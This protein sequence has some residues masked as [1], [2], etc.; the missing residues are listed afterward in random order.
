VLRAAEVTVTE[1][2]REILEKWVRN[3]ASTSHRLEERAQIVLMSAEGRNCKEQGR[4]LNVDRQRIRRWRERW[5][6]AEGRLISAEN[7]GATNKDLATI[8]TEVRSDKPRPG[9]PSKCDL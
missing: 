5:A 9:V 3:K 4:Q 6:K 7:E 2:Q 8:I 1:Q